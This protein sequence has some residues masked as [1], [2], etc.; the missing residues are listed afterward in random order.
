LQAGI[1]ENDVN[2]SWII[3]GPNFWL[4]AVAS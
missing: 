1:G 2:G 3:E 4:G